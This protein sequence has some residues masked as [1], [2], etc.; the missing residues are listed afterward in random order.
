MPIANTGEPFNFLEHFFFKGHFCL[1]SRL[2]NSSGFGKHSVWGLSVLTGS[3]RC[4]SL[5]SSGKSGSSSETPWGLI[6]GKLINQQ[7]R[8]ARLQLCLYIQCSV[9]QTFLKQISK[10]ERLRIKG[11][12][13][14]KGGV[15][16]RVPV[17][18][19]FS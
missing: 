2:K 7:Y 11:W 9:N 1:F 19:A 15:G 5:L 17:A 4:F 8:P 14:R 6:C 12:G 3:T 18:G 10:S 13:W 16:G